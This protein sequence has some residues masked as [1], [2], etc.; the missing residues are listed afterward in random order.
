[1]NRNQ[2]VSST[3]FKNLDNLI[4][5]FAQGELV[6]IG[7]RPAMGVTQFLINL[8]ITFS[9]EAAV[10]YFTPYRSHASIIDRITSSLTKI[11]MD[12]F[13][14]NNLTVNDT[15][16]I[17]ALG[18]N[19]AFNRIHIH[20]SCINSMEALKDLREK[21]I[22]QHKLKFIV[23]D[24]LQ[25]LCHSKIVSKFIKELKEL[26]V[27]CGLTVI[28]ATEINKA[29]DTRNGDRRPQLR[30]LPKNK[31]IEELS[32]KIIFVYR[33]EVYRRAIAEEGDSTT[34]LVELIVAK[35]KNGKVGRAQLKRDS[36]LTNVVDL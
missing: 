21:V 33:P 34:G 5:G 13:V 32:D 6:L 15:I 3:G 12:K 18:S 28:L 27:D 7:G 4:G 11:P 20:D 14:R 22:E 31:M 1:M 23:V 26:S 24:N 8:A 29:V 30:D 9:E 25:E 36:S 35:N 17:A 10:F 2:N 16:T 19:K